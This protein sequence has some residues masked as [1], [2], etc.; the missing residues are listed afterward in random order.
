[1]GLEGAGTRGMSSAAGREQ[2]HKHP[3]V[4]RHHAAPLQSGRGASKWD[5]PL[6]ECRF[7]YSN[8]FQS[9]LN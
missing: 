4:T 3:A 6:G 1:V 2:R 9:G 5:G 7:F 8:V